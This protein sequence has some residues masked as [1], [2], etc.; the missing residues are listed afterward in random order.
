MPYVDCYNLARCLLYPNQM[1]LFAICKRGFMK[2]L[3]M[4]ICC[5]PLV[6][7]AGIISNGS[8]EQNDVRYG[9]WSF[10]ASED[11]V[12][13]Q[14]H[15]IEIWDNLFNIQAAHGQQF[16]ELNAHCSGK[17]KKACQPGKYHIS[18]DF[19]TEPGAKYRFGLDYRAR[20]NKPEAF[21]VSIQDSSGSE[22]FEQV[23]DDHDASSWR[24]FSGDFVATDSLS[25]IRFDSMVNGSLGNL[26]DNVYVEVIPLSGFS[27]AA[28]SVSEPVTIVLFIF[29]LALLIVTRKP[30]Q[31]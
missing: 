5:L 21:T 27:A 24:N 6:S 22:V 31:S 28:L 29:A 25:R 3:L 26:I 16:I 11:V 17:G 30:K 1:V 23:I 9:G 14:G 4:F 19:I 20:T 18:Q 12:G 7:Q 15:N 8:F 2:T 13:W 10:F